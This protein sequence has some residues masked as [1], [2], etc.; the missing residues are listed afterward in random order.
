MHLLAFIL[1][2][3]PSSP[4]LCED[5]KRKPCCCVHGFKTP[6][7]NL[8]NNMAHLWID[9]DRFAREMIAAF[10]IGRYLHVCFHAHFAPAGG[11]S[12]EPAG[13]VLWW[14][15]IVAWFF[16]QSIVF[17]FFQIGRWAF[18]RP[19]DLERHIARIYAAK[20]NA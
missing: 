13:W 3:F 4:N 9:L 8:T 17:S 7:H 11:V 16:Q 5:V 19:I 15:R 10:L 18:L 12:M 14:P 20:I 2:L 1:D 6:N